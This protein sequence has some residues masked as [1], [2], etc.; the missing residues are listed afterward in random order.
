[1]N[2]ITYSKKKVNKNF[3]FNL[4]PASFQTD[5]SSVFGAA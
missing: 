2:I 3:N 5:V 1:V 4:A